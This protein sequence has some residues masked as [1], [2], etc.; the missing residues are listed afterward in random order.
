MSVRGLHRG[1]AA[2]GSATPTNAPI[3]IDSA[4]NTPKLIPAGSGS[5]QVALVTAVAASGAKVVGGSGAL[6]TGA[7]T[8][9]TGLTSVLGFSANM[10]GQPTGTGAASNQ[11][12]TISSIT[13]G[14]VVV[15][16]YA[17]SS[18]TG[19]TVAA[20]TSTGSFY[21]TAVGQ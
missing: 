11:I 17:V 18:V 8:I 3:F 5:T 4:D 19:A 6:V 9:A 7:A 21:W 20:S 10:V 12:L 14:S 16:A 13:T 1:A 15:A 2:R